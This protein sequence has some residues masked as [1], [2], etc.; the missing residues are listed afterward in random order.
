MRIGSVD[1]K[2]N[3]FLAPM[4]GVTDSSFRIICREMG[5]GLVYTEMVSSKGLYYKDK[6][7]YDIMSIENGERPVGVQ[8]FGSDPDIMAEVVS[9]HINKRNDIDVIDINMG[10]PAPKVVKNGDGSALLKDIDLIGKIVSSVVKVAKKPVTVKIRKGWDKENINALK[11]A[12]IIEESGA[13]GITVHGRTRDMFY[14]GEADW[15]IIREVKKTVK[16][17]VI[18]NGDI[19]EPKDAIEM[20]RYTGC[21]GVMIGRSARGNP[22]IFKRVLRLIQGKEDFL[23]TEEE[24]IHTAIRHM[25]LICSIKGEKRGIKE[26]RKHL[27]WYIKGM[28]NSAVIKNHVNQM[29]DKNEIEELLLEYLR[30]LRHNLRSG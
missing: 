13:Q 27:S 2:N 25:E 9:D 30:E 5:A 24:I 7:T 8:I 18:G 28:R 19:Y 23:P 20:F 17:P 12:K 22:W 15:D 11:V 16:I 3:I 10:C 26:M 1:V 6:K 14:S 29:N 21:D 4:A